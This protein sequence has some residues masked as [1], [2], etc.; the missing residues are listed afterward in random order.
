MCRRI[1]RCAPAYEGPQAVDPSPRQARCC[2]PAPRRR[3]RRR[4]R[5]TGAWQ[6]VAA[7]SRHYALSVAATGRVWP[8]RGLARG[9]RMLS[10]ARLSFAQSPGELPKRP[11]K[12]NPCHDLSTTT[13]SRSFQLL[14]HIES[15]EYRVPDV[16]A[17][18][19]ALHPG[20]HRPRMTLCGGC[21]RISGV[22]RGVK[23]AL[24]FL[25]LFLLEGVVGAD[26]A[27]LGDHGPGVDGLEPAAD[28]GEGR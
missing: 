12:P 27:C 19:R 1:S 17:E 9:R 18:A 10:Q 25:V 2:S 8:P 21:S 23:V 15:A 5:P 13:M 22:V 20:R 7:V 4:S 14:S 24:R 3:A 11:V 6:S 28:V 16:G 26:A